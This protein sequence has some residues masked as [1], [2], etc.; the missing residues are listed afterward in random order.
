[1]VGA[2]VVTGCCFPIGGNIR[3][4]ITYETKDDATKVVSWYTDK[5]ASLGWTVTLTIA[6][7]DGGEMISYKKG[8]TETT[9]TVN[10]TKSSDITDIGI[11]YN[12]V[13]TGA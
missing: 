10:V 6:G 8:E 9:A 3:V 11:M 1:M 7:Q 2:V 13:E 4:S 12:G 5:M